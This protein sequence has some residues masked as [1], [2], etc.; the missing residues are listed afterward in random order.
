M[1]IK[2]IG[3]QHIVDGVVC[4]RIVLTTR[5]YNEDLI[6]KGGAEEK[7]QESDKD[8]SHNKPPFLNET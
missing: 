1:G 4:S 6:M 2:M 7:M 5:D 3:A 8:G